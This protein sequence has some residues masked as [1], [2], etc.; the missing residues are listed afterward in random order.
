[1]KKIKVSEVFTSI[2]GES[3]YQ[4]IP[5]F[6]IRLSG[7]NLKCEYCDTKEIINK[8]I[9]YTIDELI[10]KVK[11]SK[12]GHVQITGGEPLLQVNAFFL[13]DTLVKN[14]L[15]VL[16][17]TNGSIDFSSLNKNAVVIMDIKTPSSGMEKHFDQKNLENLKVND[18]IKFVIKD[19]EDY[20]WIKKKLSE[21]D[22]TENVIFSPVHGV[23]EPLTLANWIIE[24]NLKVKLQIQLH[25]YLGLK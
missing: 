7:C 6:F 4:G 19:R 5:F 16:V 22:L 11:I 17:E 9:E 20:N 24:D 8:E 1:M 12:L 14:D 23:L 18:E 10:K 2:Q 21:Y 25:K 3:S 13:I 15:T